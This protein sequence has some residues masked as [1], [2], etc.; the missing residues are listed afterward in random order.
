MKV[1]AKILNDM[2]CRLSG[3]ISY[4][5]PDLLIRELNAAIEL[6]NAAK[7]VLKK[8]EEKANNAF[9]TGSNGKA[10]K[11]H[12]HFLS[13]FTELETIIKKVES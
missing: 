8:L 2:A 4:N 13:A 9:L 1:T 3:A 6:L 11:M 12:D 7:P 10:E 5:N